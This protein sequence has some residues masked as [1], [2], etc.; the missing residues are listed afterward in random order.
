MA[1]VDE[2]DYQATVHEV[3]AAAALAPDPTLCCVPG[4]QWALPDLDV[5]PIMWEMNYG[6]GSSVH[7][8][9]MAGQRPILYIGVGGGLEALQFAY[10]RRRPGGV[11]AVDPVG[12]MRAAAERNL[13]AA[14]ERNPWFRPEFVRILAGS[15]DDLPVEAG[16]VE[17]VAQNCLFNVFREG[18]LARALSEVR[19]VLAPGGRF[20]TS[21]PIATRP[22]PAALQRNQTLR[23]RC[24]SGCRTYQEY[25]GSL[26]AAG[27]GRIVVRA[28][29]PYRMLLPE[30]HPELDRP[31][32]LESLD[33]V[34]FR[35]EEPHGVPQIFTGRS[36]LYLGRGRFELGAGIA[37]DSGLPVPVS[38]AV[39]EQLAA[40][41]DFQV[42]ASTF[43]ADGPGCC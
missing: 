18:D 31:L 14:A 38:D 6:C 7:P 39:A 10:F 32:L 16:S 40:R 29:R 9:D 28:R 30:E 15:A 41:P 17:L 11:I 22:I 26:G 43:H 37:F 42:T 12:E 34:A 2:D 8:A 21:D 5:P 35:G 24:C 19:R 1:S 25:L 27:F 13:R 20:S 4:S 23:A 33:L 3:Y 36:A